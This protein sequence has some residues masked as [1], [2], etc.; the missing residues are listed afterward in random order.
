[1]LT[2]NSSFELK[3]YTAKSYFIM[4]TKSSPDLRSYEDDPKKSI[5]GTPLV[6][7]LANLQ[8]DYRIQLRDKKGYQYD[9]SISNIGLKDVPDNSYD[10]LVNETVIK[11]GVELRLGGVYTIMIQEILNGTFVTEVITITEPNSLNMLWM[12]PQFVLICM[13]E[14]MFSITGLEFSYTQAPMSMRSV[15][16]GCWQLTV[17]I[18]NLIVAII[19]ASNFF[20][21]QTY[22]FGLFVLIM[23]L[24]LV[25]FVWLAYCYK[26]ISLDKLERFEEC[27]QSLEESDKKIF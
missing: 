13:G 9:E 18:G 15:L 11:T 23:F 16:Q 24:G 3:S 17:G 20:D 22:V 6:R 10:V 19:V 21:S 27:E 4:G 2:V 8:S 12:V 5:R 1:M 25:L 7:I 26:P 14:V